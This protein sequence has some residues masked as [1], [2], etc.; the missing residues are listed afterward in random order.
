MWHYVLGAATIFGLI[1]GAF[2]V[3]NGRATRQLLLQEEKAT[4]ELL[5]QEEKAARELLAK[6]NETLAKMD[7]RLVKMAERLIKMDEGFKEL[8]KGLKETIEAVSK[9][10]SDEHL[11]ILEAIKELAKSNRR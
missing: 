4:R 7:E 3:Y 6:M 5:L 11:K 10:S 1:V 2:S 9:R 8:F